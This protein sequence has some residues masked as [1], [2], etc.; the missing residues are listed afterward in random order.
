MARKLAGAVRWAAGLALTLAYAA[1]L[2]ADHPGHGSHE[3]LIG[4]ALHNVLEVGIVVLA[5]GWIAYA[6]RGGLRRTD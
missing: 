3:G 2:R 5:V 1:P 6:L 4:G